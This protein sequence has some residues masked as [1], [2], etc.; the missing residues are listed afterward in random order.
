ML[1]AILAGVTALTLT[2]ANDPPDKPLAEAC[3]N[4][5]AAERTEIEAVK[6]GKGPFPEKSP[7]PELAW[8]ARDNCV[9]IAE[10]QRR[11]EIQNRDAIGAETEPGGPPPPPPNSVG[12]LSQRLE[13]NEAATFAGLWIQHQP[14]YRV[15]VAFTRD[16]ASTLAKYTNDPLF[17]PVDRPGASQAELRATQDRILE[18]LHRFDARP[19]VGMSD[20]ITGTVEISVTGDLSRF[21]RAVAR[22]EVD[23][24]AYVRIR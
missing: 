4:L 7:F 2:A 14:D 8:Y 1:S 3:P 11:M 12:S 19:S 22:G 15:V 18:A 16:A 5:S 24:P 23:L 17:K 20:I 6:S 9:T 21:R 13:A 10:A